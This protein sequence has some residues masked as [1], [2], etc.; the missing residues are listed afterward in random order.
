MN[1]SPTPITVNESNIVFNWYSLQSARVVTQE[2]N[3]DELMDFEYN[4]FNNPRT[5]WKGFLSRFFREKNITIKWTLRADNADDLVDLIDE[6]KK[7]IYQIKWV[8]KYKAKWEFR[9]ILATCTDITMKRENNNVS[10]MPFNITFQSNEPFFYNATNESF[11]FE[12]ISTS[13]RTEWINNPWSSNTS[14]YIYFIIKNAT[15]TNAVSV[16]IWGLNLSYGWT[17]ATNDI[18]LFDCKN[19][20]VL[21]NWVEVDYTW[22]FPEFVPWNNTTIFTIN[23]TFLADISVIFNKTYL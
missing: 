18:L 8:F 19:K 1:G 17:I 15:W 10:F 16:N 22:T 2:F 20:Q 21:L 14:P 11:L 5:D 4:T 9:Q 7:N 6:F 3:P 13:P 23:G 12:N